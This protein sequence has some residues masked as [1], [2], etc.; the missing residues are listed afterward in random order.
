VRLFTT[1]GR[2]SGTY[3]KIR[4]SPHPNVKDGV[5]E[6]PNGIVADAVGRNLWTPFDSTMVPNRY[7]MCKP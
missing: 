7:V 5:R 3:G 2:I 6:M 1:G 4:P